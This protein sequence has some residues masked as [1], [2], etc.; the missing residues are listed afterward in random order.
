MPQH[1]R[2]G[3]Q[4]YGGEYY[5]G[6]P[7]YDHED[8]R[9]G[10][11]LPPMPSVGY[12]AADRD[13]W[14]SECRETYYGEGKRTGGIIGGLL[15]A[16]GGGILGHEVT[17]G[18]RTRRIG[19]TLI[20]A[21]IGG[22]AGLAIGSAIGAAGDEERIDECEA[23]LQRWQGGYRPGPGY[24]YPAGYGYGYYG[25]TTVMVPV[26]V[27]AAYTYSAPIR[28]EH[29]YVIEEIIEEK[30][31]VPATKYTKYIEQAPAPAPAPAP[32]KYVKGKTVSY[33]K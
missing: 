7:Y 18:S 15:G 10:P 12:T 2:T 19:G 33:T 31:V 4:Y 23:Y 6:A 8:Y 20:G 24:G 25:Y 11:G 1:S 16:I 26:Q 21:G 32:A 28:R 29:E 5:E 13:D 30:V 27:Q 17:N 22:L 3:A 14:L 9:D